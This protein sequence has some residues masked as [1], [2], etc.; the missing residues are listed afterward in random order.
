[1]KKSKKP[2]ITITWLFTLAGDDSEKAQYS[3]TGHLVHQLANGAGAEGEV[4]HL[5]AKK[6]CT[7]LLVKKKIHQR[8]RI[9]QVQFNSFLSNESH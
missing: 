3:G 1:M 5:A 9:R 6:L 2:Q 4:E 7:A 8:G